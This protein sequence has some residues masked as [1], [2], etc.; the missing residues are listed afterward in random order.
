M[1]TCTMQGQT[2]ELETV[3]NQITLTLCL[4]CIAYATDNFLAINQFF[5]AANESKTFY[6]TTLLELPM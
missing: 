1:I 6:Q 3:I 5:F 2:A 4:G